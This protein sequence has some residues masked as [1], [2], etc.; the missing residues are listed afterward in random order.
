RRFMKKTLKK[1]APFAMLALILFPTIALAQIN[2]YINE[3]AEPLGLGTRD[4]R[5]TIASIINVALGLLGIIAVVIVIYA[6]FLW[7][8]AGGNDDQI[9]TAKG[10]MTGGIIGLVIVLS[11]YAIARFIVGSLLEATT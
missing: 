2:V 1:L 11:A 4:V 5:D 8:T 7:M 6:G 10:W 3:L 9:K